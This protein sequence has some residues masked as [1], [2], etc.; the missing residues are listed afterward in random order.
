MHYLKMKKMKKNKHISRIVQ[1]KMRL[2]I[3]QLEQEKAIRNL[4][5]DLKDDL[6]PS[7]F[8][9]NKLQEHGENTPQR[10]HLFLKLLNYGVDYI[11]RNISKKAEQT[12]DTTLQKG[13]DKLHERINT[14]F[15]NQ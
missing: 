7:N 1:E 9:R 14:L 5:H 12:I 15:R 11:G 13:V 6:K 8:L 4:W 2:R 3:Q 10:S